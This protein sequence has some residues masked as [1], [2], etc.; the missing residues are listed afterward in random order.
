[1]KGVYKMKFAGLPNNGMQE[2]E[3]NFLQMDCHFTRFARSIRDIIE[4]EIAG[5]SDFCGG[6]LGRQGATIDLVAEGNEYGEEL[7]MRVFINRGL[8]IED[9]VWILELVI[10]DI[11]TNKLAINN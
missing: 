10:K 3:K 1:M 8:E 7:G 9:I 2:E 5:R 4:D 6:R 11:E